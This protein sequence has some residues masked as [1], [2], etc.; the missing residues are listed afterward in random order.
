MK[1]KPLNDKSSY[2]LIDNINKANSQPHIARITVSPVIEKSTSVEILSPT[3][4]D[5]ITLSLPAMLRITIMIA[6]RH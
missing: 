2:F 6:E 4:E 1:N 5:E 3:V